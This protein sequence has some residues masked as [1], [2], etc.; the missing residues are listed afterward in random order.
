MFLH[1]YIFVAFV[2]Y[3]AVCSAPSSWLISLFLLHIVSCFDH[4]INPLVFCQMARHQLLHS[5]RWVGLRTFLCLQ[6]T[7]AWIEGCIS[8]VSISSE[9]Q[10]LEKLSSR[11]FSQARD[12]KCSCSSSRYYITDAN[13]ILS[14][15]CKTIERAT[16]STYFC[17]IVQA[18]YL[19]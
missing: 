7:H 4:Q 18:I 10:C 5:P 1:K 19:S 11:Y 13:A 17:A 9:K 8:I 6:R 2:K 3:V 12:S 15:L 14:K 16:S